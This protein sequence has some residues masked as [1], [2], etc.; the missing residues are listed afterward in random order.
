[1]E[2]IKNV[3]NSVDESLQKVRKKPWAEP[4]GKAMNIT[5]MVVSKCENFIPG[6]G[7][8]SGALSFG[9]SLLNPE[10][11]LQELKKQLDDLNECLKT[12]STDN[13][14]IRSIM[15][16]AMRQEIQKLE[17][18]IANPCSELR[19]DF[20]SIKS[21]MLSMKKQVQQNNNFI[22]KEVSHIKDVTRKT[23]NLVT[24]I[25]YKVNIRSL[26]FF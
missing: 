23:F 24:D 12:I 11:T 1:M 19:S 14:T 10:P 2:A 25:R 18:K 26:Y 21:E 5:G 3:K 8:I 9:S 22:T 17:E 4:L 16:N 15:E 7:I 6:A 20:D 13:D